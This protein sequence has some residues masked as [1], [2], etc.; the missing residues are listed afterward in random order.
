MCYQ[1]YTINGGSD[2]GLY[3]RMKRYSCVLHSVGD[4]DS[5]WISKQIGAYS[6]ILKNVFPLGFFIKRWKKEHNFRLDSHS[7]E[8]PVLG[9]FWDWQMERSQLLED[10]G[11]ERVV[12]REKSRYESPKVWKDLELLKEFDI[13]PVC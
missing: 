4:I 6:C 13:R 5:K 10:L 1:N 3:F 7:Q 2:K 12:D 9:D 11:V 8:R